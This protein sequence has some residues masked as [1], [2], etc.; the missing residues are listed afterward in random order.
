[1]SVNLLQ[2]GNQGTSG[3]TSA[4]LDEAD[5]CVPYFLRIPVEERANK[6]TELGTYA[7]LQAGATPQTQ[8]YT[9]VDLPETVSMGIFHVS[10]M[11][12]GIPDQS[13]NF[14]VGEV[15]QSFAESEFCE[16]GMGNGNPFHLSSVPL[17]LQ[18]YWAGDFISG[19]ADGFPCGQE[20]E[21]KTVQHLCKCTGR[22]CG[23]GCE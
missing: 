19:R 16:E 20:D 13:E 12:G 21:G 22:S 11:T 15:V 5:D 6:C 3:D 7:P 9:Y 17:R 18:E 10:V 1:L 4:V 14:D 2:P 23:Q 8:P